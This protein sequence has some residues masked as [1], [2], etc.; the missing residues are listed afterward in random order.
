MNA[1]LLMLFSSAA[2]AQDLFRA[3]FD[4]APPAGVQAENVSGDPTAR[5]IAYDIGLLTP[6]IRVIPDRMLWINGV[7]FSQTN[8][9]IF[10]AIGLNDEDGEVNL[11]SITLDMFFAASLNEKWSLLAAVIPG[12]HGNL[13]DGLSG[14][15]FLMQGFI[16]ATVKLNERIALGG[17]GGYANLF[18]VPQPLALVQFTYKG[19]R[20]SADVLL[21]RNVDLWYEVVDE[22]WFVGLQ[23]EIAGGYYHIAPEQENNPD[24]VFVQYSV[25]TF[26]PSLQKAFGP[27]K[28]TANVGWMGFRRYNVIQNDNPD[29]LFEFELDPA[30][31]ASISL[32]ITPPLPNSTSAQ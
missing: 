17:G 22:S 11:Y 21:P 2:M 27:L 29:P 28:L 15:D 32:T 3:S 12:I 19:D 4:Y 16:L 9:Q 26:G 30:L 8:S 23:S 20:F 24:N 6:P 31:N 25:G 1:L 10:D 14:Q 5:F 13:V 18:G 7:S